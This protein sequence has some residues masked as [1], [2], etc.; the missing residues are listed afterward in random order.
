V[1]ANPGIRSFSVGAAALLLLGLGGCR[2]TE[3][4]ES[5]HIERPPIVR[6]SVTRIWSVLLEGSPVGEVVFFESTDRV[7]DSIYMVRNVWQQD[8]GL[9]DSLGRAYRFT[10]HSEEPAWVGT[11]TVTQGA[12]RILRI[13]ENCVLVEETE[14]PVGWSLPFPA[15]EKELEPELEPG[16]GAGTSEAE[17]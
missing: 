2:T 8:L 17:R 7:E 9:I 10:P 14:E 11:G 4:R 6:A 1:N 3:T 16:T 5:M 15:P 12:A 13:D